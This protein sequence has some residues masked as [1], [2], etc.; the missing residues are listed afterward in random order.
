MLLVDEPGPFTY[1]PA[2]RYLFRFKNII[3]FTSQ[4]NSTVTFQ[5]LTFEIPTDAAD[6]LQLNSF[7]LKQNYPNPFNPSTTIKYSIPEASKIILL[8]FDPLGKEVERLVQEETKA[9]TYEIH[10]NFERLSSGIYFYQL[11]VGK[12]IETKKMI[13]MK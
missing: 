11:Q 7:D 10:F 3:E 4:I 8:V 13:L 2:D 6:L 5:P 12:Y 1:Y 9:G